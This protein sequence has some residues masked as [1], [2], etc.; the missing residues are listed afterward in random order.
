MQ[1]FVC[2]EDQLIP[3]MQKHV[4][5]IEFSLSLSLSSAA[6]ILGFWQQVGSLVDAL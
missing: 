4:G 3:F 6:Q 5:F 2:Q 1:I